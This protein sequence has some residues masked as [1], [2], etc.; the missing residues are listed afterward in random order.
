MREYCP[1]AAMLGVT[2]HRGT[3][4]S[5]IF[6]VHP[7]KESFYRNLLTNFLKTE[8]KDCFSEEPV[9]H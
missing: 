5:Y 3:Q 2:F 4:R 6:V 1:D 9:D 8:W 7:D